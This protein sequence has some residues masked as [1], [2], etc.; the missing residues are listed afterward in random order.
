MKKMNLFTLWIISWFGV[1]FVGTLSMI[2][3]QPSSAQVY[4]LDAL[5]GNDANIGDSDHPW[6]T[7]AR[8]LPDWAGVGTKVTQGDTVLISPGN[9]GRFYYQDSTSTTRSDW[10][11]YRAKDIKNMPIFQNVSIYNTPKVYMRFEYLDIRDT[12]SSAAF[13][14]VGKLDVHQQNIQIKNCVFVYSSYHRTAVNLLYS[15]NTVVEDCNITNCGYG[16]LVQFSDYATIRNN[17]IHHPDADGIR[18]DSSSHL[19]IEGNHIHDLWRNERNATVH[20]D[21]LQIISWSA[22]S[23]H[24]VN[25][26]KNVMHTG[27]S[28]GIHCTTSADCYSSNI[29]VENNLLYGPFG[30]S[31]IDF[32]NVHGLTFVNNTVIGS[33]GIGS[34]IG[35][36]CTNVR[37]HNNIFAHTMF[38]NSGNP[39][40]NEQNYNIFSKYSAIK[41]PLGAHDLISANIGFVDADNNDFAL[42]PGSVAIDFGNPDFGPV[43]DILGHSRTGRPDAGCYEFVEPKRQDYLFSGDV[44]IT[45]MP[46]TRIIIEVK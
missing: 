45:A 21:F 31:Q 3:A 36:G 44:N 38:S 17:N 26:I 25:I 20:I 37:I 19:Q 41:N 27:E 11:T 16:V 9:Y 12:N 30:G 10:I 8:A 42:A 32:T 15:D 40:T 46:G 7:I 28:Q 1:F 13:H 39:N 35:V 2:F 33:N 24:D 14:A 29:L 43:S 18:F 34:S 5:N 22:N 6:R 4:F 23:V